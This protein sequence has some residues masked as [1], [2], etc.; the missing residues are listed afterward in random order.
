VKATSRT[1]WGPSRIRC[2]LCSLGD[3]VR[4]ALALRIWA[5]EVEHLVDLVEGSPHVAPGGGELGHQS[6][7]HL[8]LPEQ[9]RGLIEQPVELISWQRA[10][11]PNASAQDL[12]LG[13]RQVWTVG[14]SDHC[15]NYR[16]IHQTG[17]YSRAQGSTCSPPNRRLVERRRDRSISM[18]DT[19][20]PFSF[21]LSEIQAH[22]VGL[23]NWSPGQ[24]GHYLDELLADEAQEIAWGRRHLSVVHGKLLD[25]AEADALDDIVCALLDLVDGRW[26]RFGGIADRHFT[27]TV[28]GPAAEDLIADAADLA[29]RTKPTHWRVVA[30]AIVE[31]LR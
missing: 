30:T 13:P 15:T 5:M 11:R 23:R 8:P 10:S 6:S 31:V 1:R 4:S 18:Q 20:D 3:E 16:S 27:L 19:Y 24:R 17:W 2:Q 9:T 25:E 21:L 22:D 7:H 12:D 26:H 14:H 29:T 28:D